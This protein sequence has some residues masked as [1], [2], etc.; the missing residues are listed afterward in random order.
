MWTSSSGSC[1]CV[2]LCYVGMKGVCGIEV[3]VLVSVRCIRCFKCVSWAM[4]CVFGV[5]GYGCVL[6]SMKKE[7]KKEAV[8][9]GD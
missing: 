7:K 5:Y 4:K 9:L 2:L 1:R 6:L 3:F 8:F